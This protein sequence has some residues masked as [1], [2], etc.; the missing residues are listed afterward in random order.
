MFTAVKNFNENQRKTE[1]PA[2]TATEPEK[3]PK[4]P[5][6]KCNSDLRKSGMSPGKVPRQ[7]RKQL[8]LAHAVSAEVKKKL[9]RAGTPGRVALD[10]VLPPALYLAGRS[11]KDTIACGTLS[12]MTGIGRELLVKANKKLSHPKKKRL[13]DKSQELIE[14][15][16]HYFPGKKRQFLN[17]PALVTSVTISV[18]CLILF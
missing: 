14:R 7:I 3:S 10:E 16:E 9:S 11:L 17:D 15:K 4:T 12:K 1:K 5:R 18:T 8:V 13:P 6:S 2:A